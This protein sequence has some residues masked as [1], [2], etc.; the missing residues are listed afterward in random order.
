MDESIGDCAYGDG[1][2]RQ[3]FADAGRTLVA[4]VPTAS[5]QGYL[6]K[7]AFTLD[8]DGMTCTCPG[9]QTTAEL[10]RLTGGGGKFQF[11]AAVCAACPL[12]VQCVRGRGGRTVNLHP[13]EALL[14]AARQVQA[15][16]AFQEYRI[17]RQ[18][19]EHRI[20]R[21]MQLG[22]RQGRYC[23]VAK[24]L[25]QA[26]LAAAVANLTLLAGQ[27]DTEQAAATALPLAAA[28]VMLLWALRRRAEPPDGLIRA[29]R[30]SA[31]VSAPPTGQQPGLLSARLGVHGC[32]PRF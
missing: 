13:Q 2:T 19:V 23:G 27:V 5:N 29:V 8:L 31:P 1:A 4:K 17:R 11:A 20:A 28:L 12:R 10:K 14:Q 30:A 21:L 7:T 22:V 9:G 16:P 18:V 26:C 15:S 32:R 24:T 6:P 3:A 25:V